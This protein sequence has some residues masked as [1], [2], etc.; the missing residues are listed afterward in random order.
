MSSIR[1]VMTGGGTGGHLYPLLALADYLKSTGRKWEITFIGTERNIEARVVP[2]EGYQI[3]FVDVEGVIGRGIAGKLRALYKLPGAIKRALD[4]LRNLRPAIVIGS[5][6]YVSFPGVIAAYLDRVP[7]VLLEQNAVPGR[8]N[9]FLS[10]FA[11]AVCVTDPE[12]VRYFPV[13]KVF[14]TGNPVRQTILKGSREAGYKLFGLDKDRFTVFVFGGSRGA[15]RINEAMC[16]ALK[17][18]GQLRQEVQFLHQTGQNDLERVR[19][20][21]RKM[22]F[23]GTVVSYIYQMPEAYAVADLVVSRSGASTIAELSATSKPAILV[24]YPYAA[25]DHQLKNALRLQ[26]MNAAEIIRDEDL[27][28]QTLA[29]RILSL[30]EDTSRREQLKRNIKAFSKIDATERVYEVIKMVLKRHGVDV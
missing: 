9:R 23:K 17:Y 22:G 11:E 6:G 27:N 16:D 30:Y 2:K 25:G 20:C 15:R 28:G 21:Y 19:D 24:P 26:G 14:V 4:C 18:L 12:S 29:E 3:F 7:S 10:R 8:A 13:R 5:G 1:M